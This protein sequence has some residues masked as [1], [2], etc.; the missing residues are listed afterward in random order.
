V[1]Y[2][3]LDLSGA[4][5]GII[6]IPPPVHSYRQRFHFNSAKQSAASSVLCSDQSHGQ[7]GCHEKK[8]V[9]RK[10]ECRPMVIIEQISTSLGLLFTEEAFLTITLISGKSF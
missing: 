5:C 7:F 3:N 6:V 1:R 10:Q 4:I 9:Y 2:L 8:Q